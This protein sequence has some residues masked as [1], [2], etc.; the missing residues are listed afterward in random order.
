MEHLSYYFYNQAG[1]QTAHK[2]YRKLP[3]DL[4]ESLKFAHL[5]PKVAA[6]LANKEKQKHEEDLFGDGMGKKSLMPEINQA[7]QHIKNRLDSSLLNDEDSQRYLFEEAKSSAINILQQLARI[8]Y[9]YEDIASCIPRSLEYQLMTGYREL[10]ADVIFV[11]REWQTLASREQFLRSLAE[12]GSDEDRNFVDDGDGKTSRLEVNVK[13]KKKSSKL[14]LPE[15]TEMEE[16]GR[17]TGRRSDSK[18]SPVSRAR[19]QG[20]G[21]NALGMDRISV[22]GSVRSPGMKRGH[23]DDLMSALTETPSEV[24]SIMGVS[25]YYMSIIQFQLSS[26]QCEEK[27]WIVQKGHENEIARDTLLEWCVH[28]L[29]QS[30]KTTK[31]QQLHDKQNGLDKPV[32]VR[33]YGDTRKETLLKYRKSPVKQMPNPA[34][35]GQ[36]PRIPRM[37]NDDRDEGKALCVTSHLDGTSVVYY[38]SGRV[39]IISSAAGFGRPGYYLLAYDDDQEMRM[40]ACFTPSGKGCV[41]HNNGIIR[42]LATHKGGHVADEEGSITQRWKWPYG[43]IKI[44]NPVSFQ[45]NSS[46]VFRCMTQSQMVVSFSCKRETCK[47]VVGPVAGAVEPKY[48][49]ENEQLLTAFTFSSLAAKELLNLFSPKTKSKSKSKKK[50]DRYKGQLAELQKMYEYQEKAL[51]DTDADK[52]LARL[53]RKARNLVDDWMEH[54]RITVGLSSPSLNMMSDSPRM[55][56]RYSQSAKLSDDKFNRQASLGISSAEETKTRALRAP[57]APADPGKRAKTR[58]ARQRESPSRRSMTASVKFD[59]SADTVTAG[60][61]ADPHTPTTP[62]A[63]AIMNRL[64]E[65]ATKS[66]STRSHSKSP[67]RQAT[68]TSSPPERVLSNIGACPSA[69]RQMLLGHDKPQCH[70]SRH[71]VTYITDV[72]FDEFMQKHALEGQLQIVAVVSSL[73]PKVLSAED[74]LDELYVKMNRNR[75]RPCLQCR[76]DMYRILKYDINSAADNT[77]HTQP[78]LLTR[79]NVVPGMFLIYCDGRLLFCDHI[80]NGYGNT[81]KDFK[82]QI[83]NSRKDFQQG[84]SLPKDFKFSPSRGCHGPRS[85]WGGEIG[86]TGIDHHGNPGTS[87]R[88]RVPS[89]CSSNKATMAPMIDQVKAIYRKLGSMIDMVPW[90]NSQT[91]VTSHR[92]QGIRQRQQLSQHESYSHHLPAAN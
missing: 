41:Y 38:P 1:Y 19:S 80:F 69:I 17:N 54:Y 14:G 30:M 90:S 34:L 15:I 64:V 44:T 60:G 88:T 28:R 3:E 8:I 51:Y 29:Q 67:T 73:F 18:T 49:D 22:C 75:T 91:S 58:S 26:K 71:V 5:N 82:K 78:L 21:K 61:E 79:H 63:G 57:S 45:I 31:Q 74:M 66:N 13:P 84:F 11:P 48:G 65:A 37:Y 42:F 46:L 62:S 12:Q 56:V 59:H 32:Q 83:M 10:T 2:R 92:L 89:D 20:R 7:F 76:T 36:K 25:G 72:E 53:Q 86:G 6:Y 47:F 16:T 27:G 68:F 52:D 70:C 40:L 81:K 23:G 33:Y 50:L 9:Y 55:R 77:N 4:P 39:A 87:L 24:R 85:A 43:N 35:K